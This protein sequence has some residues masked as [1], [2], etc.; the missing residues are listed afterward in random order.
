[1]CNSA[2]NFVI[3]NEEC[4]FTGGLKIGNTKKGLLIDPVNNKI[5][6]SSTEDA[7]YING[8]LIIEKNLTIGEI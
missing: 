8:K 5:S 2:E 6:R 1:M 7:I 3:F 4:E